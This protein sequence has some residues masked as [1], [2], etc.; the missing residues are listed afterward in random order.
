VRLR[1]HPGIC[2]LQGT[3]PMVN[4]YRVAYPCVAQ[5]RHKLGATG[6]SQKSDDHKAFLP[7]MDCLAQLTESKYRENTLKVMDNPLI[8]RGWRGSNTRPLASETNTLSTE[9][10]PH[11]G[12]GPIVKFSHEAY[13]TIGFGAFSGARPQRAWWYDAVATAPRNLT[14]PKVRRL[15]TS[16]RSAA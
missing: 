10:Q 16:A 11:L 7:V 4:L 5:V 2:F 6:E 14:I 1:E 8:W 9:L 3:E 12:A 13:M 15:R